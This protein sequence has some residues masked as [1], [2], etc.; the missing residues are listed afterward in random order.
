[1]LAAKRRGEGGRPSEPRENEAAAPAPAVDPA[2]AEPAT[3]AEAEAEANIA[4]APADCERAP[5]K[6]TGVS[7]EGN[8]EVAGPDPELGI[9]EEELEEVPAPN[10]ARSAVMS[11]AE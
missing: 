4:A 11:E 8:C 6:A 2:A 1:M 5:S 10:D 3:E 7:V 9:E